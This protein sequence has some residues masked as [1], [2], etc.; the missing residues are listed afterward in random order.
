MDGLLDTEA[1]DGGAQVLDGQRA[2]PLL[3]P[4]DLIS[5]VTATSDREI[6]EK[7]TIVQLGVADHRRVGAA[8]QVQG[9]QRTGGQQILMLIPLVRG[10][11]LSGLTGQ[12]A[13]P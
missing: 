10:T 1:Q 5:P 12:L 11:E 8:G 13:T 3:V 6:V 9:S 7:I 4:L 2:G